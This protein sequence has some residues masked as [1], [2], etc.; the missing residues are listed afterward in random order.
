MLGV[1]GDLHVRVLGFVV[2]GRV[3]GH[4]DGRQGGHQDHPDAHGVVVGHE[5]DVG[6]D[7][8]FLVEQ[9]RVLAII[10]GCNIR[11]VF[12]ERRRVGFLHVIGIQNRHQGRKHHRALGQGEEQVDRS[13]VAAQE[14]VEGPGAETP[15]VDADVPP[16][17]LAPG[18]DLR[19]IK[20]PGLVIFAVT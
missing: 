14:V 4:G 7:S 15:P 2:G 16:G 9:P 19:S 11:C 5:V 10:V 1:V 6:L 8:G 20:G 12:I 18:S 17:G 3:I 13:A